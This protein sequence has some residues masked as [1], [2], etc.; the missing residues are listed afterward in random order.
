MG[1]KTV[2]FVLGFPIDENRRWWCTFSMSE[3]GVG[4]PIR[5]QKTD[6]KDIADT[7][8][9]WKL[10]TEGDRGDPRTDF[11]WATETWA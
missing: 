2:H 5:S 1:K 11:K 6:V 8:G 9:G 4:I 3:V 10:E 7:L